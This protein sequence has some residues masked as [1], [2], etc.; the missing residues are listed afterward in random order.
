MPNPENRATVG[1]RSFGFLKVEQSEG[2]ENL[3][4]AQRIQSVSRRFLGWMKP[5]WGVWGCVSEWR[6]GWGCPWL[7]SAGFDQPGS[8]LITLA[9]INKLRKHTGHD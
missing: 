3:A 7:R 4:N 2:K 5:V 1:A 9:L 6:E 8:G